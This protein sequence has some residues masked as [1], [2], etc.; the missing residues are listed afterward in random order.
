MFSLCFYYTGFFFFLAPRG[1]G[2]LCS[3]TKDGTCAPCSGSSESEPL[4]CQGIPYIGFWIK[5]SCLVC[6]KVHV[7]VKTQKNENNGQRIKAS[8]ALISLPVSVFSKHK[9]SKSRCNTRPIVQLK[10]SLYMP[11]PYVCVCLQCTRTT[12]THIQTPE[13]K[14]HIHSSKVFE[15]TSHSDVL[16]VLKAGVSM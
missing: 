10:C 12:H 5:I 15:K 4:D 3:P 13:W 7:H 6:P 9:T 16:S 8:Q 1:L 14:D 11:K 2:D